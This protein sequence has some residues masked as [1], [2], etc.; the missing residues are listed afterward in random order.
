MLINNKTRNIFLFME[1]INTKLKFTGSEEQHYTA[2]FEG[3]LTP[4][5]SFIYTEEMREFLKKL[6]LSD[7]DI[8]KVLNLILEGNKQVFLINFMAGMR[9]CSL[10]K[11]GKKYSKDDMYKE[12][13]ILA[14]R[15]KQ[16]PS[17][18]Q[19]K[20][21]TASKDPENNLLSSTRNLAKIIVE[22]PVLVNCG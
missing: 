17:A 11:Q 3:L 12:Q 8:Q 4:G 16:I 1:L 10:I 22:E 21:L 20:S 18:P 5:Q 19:T 6:K 14:R 7:H 2:E 15:N 13:K 9:L